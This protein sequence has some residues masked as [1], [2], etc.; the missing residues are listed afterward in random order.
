MRS[1]KYIILGAML[2]PL[3]AATGVCADTITVTIPVDEI[4]LEIT[5][6]RNGA[7]NSTSINVQVTT[8]NSAGY[9]LSMT[10]ASTVLVGMGATISTFSDLESYV[11][12]AT[13]TE[14]EFPTNY[15]GF[16]KGDESSYSA[17]GG[18][19]VIA[20][21]SSS[22]ANVA[23][24]S[25]VTFAAKLDNDKPAGNY[26]TTLTFTALG[27]IPYM[28]DYSLA[29]CADELNKSTRTKN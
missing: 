18:T 15:W 6:N 2:A 21:S 7:F 4:S 12:G 10:P 25:V 11:A 13:Y 22:V 5:P 9:T 24:T 23:E 20:D 17:V 1:K 26:A 27:K 28:Q 3:C 19:N 14:A 16:K 29:T 8:G